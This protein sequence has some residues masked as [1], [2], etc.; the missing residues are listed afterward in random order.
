VFARQ[1]PVP[2]KHSLVSR[3]DSLQ[4]QLLTRA[5]E[6]VMCQLGQAGDDLVEVW[7]RLLY[8][9]DYTEV[10]GTRCEITIMDGGHEK[11]G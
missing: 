1:R 4:I 3:F 6:R 11:C 10:C 2:C 8:E 5:F 7:E 9:T